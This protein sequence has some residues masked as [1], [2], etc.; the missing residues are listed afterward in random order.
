MNLPQIITDND[1]KVKDALDDWTRWHQTDDPVD[2]FPPRSA[3]L[4]CDGGAWG[5]YLADQEEIQYIRNAEAIEAILDP[6]SKLVTTSQ[7]LS[8]HH[9]HLGAVWRSNR[10]NIAEDYQ[11]ALQIIEINLRK[12]NLI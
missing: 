11:Q 6:E 10:T 2:G 8:V 9:F 5:N 3:V 1:R 7:R 4:L 12:R